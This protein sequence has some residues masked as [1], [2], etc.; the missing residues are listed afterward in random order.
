[1]SFA[2]DVQNNFD[3]SK[4][5]FQLSSINLYSRKKKHFYSFLFKWRFFDFSVFP[6]LQRTQLGDVPVFA[7][8]K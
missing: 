3:A 6:S 4:E 2:Y 8:Q 5:L 1:M 7:K